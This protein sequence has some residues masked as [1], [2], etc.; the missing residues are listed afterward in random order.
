MLL[1]ITKN[2]ISK[3]RENVVLNLIFGLDLTK[4]SISVS[5]FFVS[6]LFHNSS[7]FLVL[8]VVPAVVYNP[9]GCLTI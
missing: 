4:V 7:L 8:V 9:P 5:S 3:A 2:Q 1:Y 6:F